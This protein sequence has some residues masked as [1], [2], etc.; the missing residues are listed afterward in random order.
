VVQ[1]FGVF[2]AFLGASAA[3]LRTDAASLPRDARRNN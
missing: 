1:G 2:M 3:T